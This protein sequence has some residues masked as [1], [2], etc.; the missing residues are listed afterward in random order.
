LRTKI[1]HAG[2]LSAAQFNDRLKRRTA[3]L[4]DLASREASEQ[5]V[6]AAIAAEHARRD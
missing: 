3:I 1:C 2:G 5:D 4:A 6:L